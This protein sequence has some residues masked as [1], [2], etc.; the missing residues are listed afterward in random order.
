VR[1][2]KQALAARNHFIAERADAVVAARLY[3]RF[4]A[5]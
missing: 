1:Y 5:A 4:A 2:E 3:Q